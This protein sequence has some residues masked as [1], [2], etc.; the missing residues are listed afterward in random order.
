[1]S[2]LLRIFD[3]IALPKKP[4]IIAT[5]IIRYILTDNEAL[6]KQSNKTKSIT[7]RMTS[8]SMPF[9]NL[10]FLAIN[11]ENVDP[12]N[13]DI[14]IEINMKIKNKFDG[15]FVFNIISENIESNTI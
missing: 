14:P 6:L 8:V 5:G 4:K 10:D 13:T 9:K 15:I 7:I 1:M 2:Y 3:P 12:I 11:D